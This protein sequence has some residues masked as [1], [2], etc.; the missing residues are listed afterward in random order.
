VLGLR[1]SRDTSC[2][3]FLEVN[4]YSN[5]NERAV[6]FAINNKQRYSSLIYL[7]TIINTY[8]EAPMHFNYIRM[9]KHYESLSLF[10][11]L[12]LFLKLEDFS[13]LDDFDR[14]ELGGKEVL[15]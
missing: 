5:Y 9:V 14:I 6:Y 12:R 15:G 11:N 7:F 2:P 8:V 13:L 10:E 4:K 3:I 1:Q